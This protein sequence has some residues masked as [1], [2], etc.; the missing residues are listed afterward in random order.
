MMATEKTWLVIPYDELSL[1]KEAAKKLPQ[2]E[3]ALGFDQDLKLWFAKPGA[4]LSALQRWR[5]DP[6][7]QAPTKRDPRDEFAQVL[8]EAGFEL[9]GPPEMDGQLHR[10]KTSEDKSG[11]KTGAYTGYLDGTPAG[12]Y[13]NHRLHSDPIK[14]KATPSWV[15][16]PAQHHLRALAA[17]KKQ[18]R[19]E[20]QARKY[21]HHALR[22]RQFFA[23]LPE[24]EA[25][26]P[27]LRRKGI[28]L[29]Q[30]IKQDRQGRL[31]IPLR[32]A[33]GD[34]RTIQRID[35]TGFKSLKKGAQK[36][37]GFF[38]VGG[39]VK[40]GQPLL[41]AEGYA[42]AASIAQ[43]TGLPVVMTV[44]AG[45][46]P[47]VAH[48][49][50]QRYPD[51]DHFFLADDDRKNATNKGV[52]KAQEAAELT[53]GTVILPVFTQAEITQN[54][55][56]FND[57]QQS[58]GVKAVTS[59]IAPYL[60]SGVK[61]SAPQVNPAP[62]V[63]NNESVV[64]PT[65]QTPIQNEQAPQVEM[66][67]KKEPSHV[68][69]RIEIE[70]IISEKGEK[71]PQVTPINIDTLM[72]NITHRYENGT[73]VYFHQGE[74]DFV[75]HGQ[76]ITMASPE[77]SQN[78]TMVL[79]A[80]WLAKQHYH[81]K[82][83]LTGSDAFKQK[84]IDVIAEHRLEVVLKNPQ[85]QHQLERAMQR[86]HQDKEA[87]STEKPQTDALVANRETVTP[88]KTSSTAPPE[89][90]MEG[91]LTGKLLEHRAAPYQF[92]AEKDM[93]YFVRMRTKEGEKVIW[94]KELEGALNDS[95]MKTGELITLRCLGQQPL[96]LNIPIKDAQGNLVR[97]EKK[98]GHRTQWEMASAIDP[99]LLVADEK[100]A[101]PPSA[102]MAYDRATFD[103]IQQAVLTQT[104]MTVPLPSHQSDWLWLQP[105][106]KGTSKTGHPDRGVLPTT[107]PDSGKTVMTAHSPEGKMRLHL[108]QGQGDSVQGM[109]W[110]QGAYR[111]A[112]GVL[113]QKASG[114]PYLRLNV[115]D[116]EGAR[117]MGYGHA[118]NQVD[119]PSKTNRFVF[120]L[121]GEKD[122]VI[123]QMEKP[124]NRVAEFDKKWGFKAPYPPVTMSP[125]EN[126][127]LRVKEPPKLDQHD[128]PSP[129]P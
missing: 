87:K 116:K 13:Q 20:E 31:V 7:S 75:D 117:P 21:Q 120:R 50:A 103:K 15:D 65:S 88:Q 123:A 46:M 94:G 29:T 6:M 16:K 89:P 42:T 35:K 1:A 84:A 99:R 62:P 92:K 33:E 81:G 69:N 110:H 8:I 112:L 3:N 107:H 11:Q 78:N 4:D 72:Q 36:T 54:L 73:V 34:I 97:W 105:D 5:P 109:V 10:V 37:G 19:E 63:E 32:N 104:A 51:N 53:Q 28:P 71:G 85:Q 39:T 82:I 9:D 49:L 106:G 68:E 52:Q 76:Q 79:A 60:E 41:Y 40:A 128:Y 14:W 77:A 74:R 121:E 44:D 122:P 126:N 90:T 115:V 102:L 91:P 47:K 26:H 111:H 23:L 18:T 86:L 83:E 113:C 98:E 12:W 58:Q 108:V 45:N 61:K 66:P 25:S 127:L 125:E 38:V 22:V 96:T 80:L 100:D 93:S 59:Q 119:G 27:Y 64:M 129:A 56:D 2:G 17:Q 24:A 67:D 95:G 124:E 57:L 43:A 114:A 118:L 48:S 30:G 55:T 101:F 70:P